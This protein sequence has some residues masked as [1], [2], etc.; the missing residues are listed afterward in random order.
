MPLRRYSFHARPSS[1]R[2]F[3][4]LSSSTDARKIAVISAG[5]I[6]HCSSPP[7][8]SE[9][10]LPPVSA[11][12]SYVLRQ[13]DPRSKSTK[14]GWK[15]SCRG[16]ATAA[17]MA[18]RAC[19]SSCAAIRTPGSARRDTAGAGA[20]GGGTHSLTEGNEGL[21]RA[22]PKRVEAQIASDAR[23]NRSL[24]H[25]DCGGG[26]AREVRLDDLGAGE[27]DRRREERER[28]GHGQ[29]M[30]PGDGVTLHGSVLYF[31]RH[32]RSRGIQR[33]VFSRQAR[34]SYRLVT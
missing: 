13:P 23:S 28:H 5:A 26:A 11:I 30:D 22:E 25:D 8:S 10:D 7:F 2:A 6:S 12:M 9:G 3:R 14:M 15:I 24:L 33:C 1:R 21:I 27:R 16:H 20:R 31:P 17:S 32:V 4:S 18:S 29:T 34:R 19:L